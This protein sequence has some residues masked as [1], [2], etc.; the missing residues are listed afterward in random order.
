ME[1]RGA[2][3]RGAA[4]GDDPSGT[5]ILGLVKHLAANEYGW[6]CFTFGR[7]T[8]P[9]PFVDDDPEADLRIEP[10]ETTAD[11]LAFY[12]R[13]RAAADKV[14]EELDLDTRWARRGAA[15]RCRCAG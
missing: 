8:E 6:F 9:L 15:R 7:E 14:I 4:A 5:N 2:Q 3:R 1:A 11:V 10:H 13:A 12:S